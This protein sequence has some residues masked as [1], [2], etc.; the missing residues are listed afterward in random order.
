MGGRSLGSRGRKLL[1][2]DGLARRAWTDLL[3]LML[4]KVLRLLCPHLLALPPFRHFCRRIP[5]PL[6]HHAIAARRAGQGPP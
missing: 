3:L 1:L 6:C 2:P 4:E 5:M